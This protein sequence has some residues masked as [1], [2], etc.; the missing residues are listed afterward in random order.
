MASQPPYHKN[1]EKHHHAFSGAKIIFWI[2][3]IQKPHQIHG[4]PPFQAPTKV[5]VL[6]KPKEIIPSR[7][8]NRYISHLRKRKLKIF[9]LLI[10]RKGKSSKPC[11]KE[12]L[13]FRCFSFGRF[14]SF[15][16]SPTFGL[17]DPGRVSPRLLHTTCVEKWKELQLLKSYMFSFKER[18][19]CNFQQ[20]FYKGG[21]KKLHWKSTAISCRRIQKPYAP[22]N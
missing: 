16:F 5:I 2:R 8:R 14:G 1:Y 4:L 12:L 19:R 9:N 21:L 17:W 7:E 15:F 13:F 6:N 20:P 22:W 11:S 3:K 18:N 10:P